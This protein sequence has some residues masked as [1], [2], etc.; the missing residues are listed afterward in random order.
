VV[1]AGADQTVNEGDIVDLDPATFTDPG[2][3]D[4][5]TATVDWGDGTPPEPGVVDE[6]HG[7][8]TV[9]GSHV[10][11]DNGVY[12][13]TVTVTDDDGASDSDTLTMTVAN[14]APVVEAGADQT[15]DEGDT[16]S[17]DPATFVDPG[18]ADAHTATVDWGDGTPPEPGVVDEAAG[19]VSGDHVYADNGVCTVTVSVTD[20][21]GGVGA[22]AMAVTVLNVAPSFDAGDDIVLPPSTGGMLPTRAITFTDPGA[23]EWSGTVNFGD[24][25][26]DEPLT[27]DQETKTF[28]LDHTYTESGTYT[29]SVTVEDDDGGSFTDT[30]MVQVEVDLN[31]P[32][33]A[34]PGGPYA[35]DEGGTV[36]LDA[37][38][39]SDAEQPTASLVF[40]W[41]LDGDGVFGETGAAAERGDEVGVDPTFSAVGS[42]G[43]SSVSVELRVT[44]DEGETDTTTASIDIAN[45]APAIDGILVPMDPVQAGSAATA[46]GTFSDPGTPDT[47]VAVW[48]WG[49]GTTSTIGNAQELVVAEHTYLAA[50][51]YTIK[52]T[53][54][55]DDGGTHELVCQQ[56]VV[57]YDAS[58]GFVTGGGWI[59]SPPGA[60]AADPEL[61][62][63]ANFGFV[64]KYK[65][66]ADVPTGQTN[67]HFRVADLHFHSTE[68]QWLVVA[69][70]RAQFKG[71]GT[72]NGEGDYGF[73]LVGID[74]QQNGGG[75]VDKFRIKI[76]DKATGAEQPVYD[77]KMGSDDYGN[78]ATELGGGSIVI[79]KD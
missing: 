65:T 4:T 26:G 58:G 9:A 5:H 44:D 23:D 68:Y 1:E 13:V 37:S 53:V 2:T 69:G 7:S 67:F 50:G 30:V 74:G 49:D 60:Y 28:G 16:V 62:G 15:V 43:P 25:T 79:H 66:G 10:Y 34:D 36:L 75:G 52:L 61:T 48:D 35:V 24:G 12:T 22:D 77:N 39:S 72:I 56:Y 45:V 63:K 57:V 73:M 78:D 64:A 11:A 71:S 46:T 51:V 41:D 14:V 6:A 32:P 29:V 33:V 38:G 18:T 19:T 54:T 70:A 40:E 20:D 42:D 76:W 55:D 21:D 47:H 59:Q 31:T 17:L 27:I 8:G 3:A